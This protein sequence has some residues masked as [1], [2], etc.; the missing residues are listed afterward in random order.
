MEQVAGVEFSG[1][2]PGYLNR[3]SIPEEDFERHFLIAGSTKVKSTFPVV[4]SEKN[5]RRGNVVQAWAQ[6]DTIGR[7]IEQQLL[8]L[9]RQFDDDPLEDERPSKIEEL[10]DSDVNKIQVN[11]ELSFG[12]STEESL[13]FNQFSDRIGVGFNEY[14]VRENTN[15]SGELES[16][17][18]VFKAM[19]PGPPERRNGV[20]ITE[21]FLREVSSKEYAGEEPH[22]KDHETKN[23]FARIG[24]IEDLW[25]SDSVEALMLMVNTPNV[26]G[27][28]NHEE[29]I[30]RYTHE[31]P[32]IRDGSVGFGHQYEAVVN[33]DGEPELVDGQVQ[34]FSTVNF[35]GGYD[36]G[37]V[38]AAF[39]EAAQEAV[40]VDDSPEEDKGDENLAAFTISTTQK[41]I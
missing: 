24:G 8:S 6:R 27:S 40:P 33:D 37:G 36:E 19:E 25:Y 20:R 9:A 10:F 29:A 16:V 41:S 11:E 15:D 34:E 28:R 2:K 5:L 31:P 30:A 35:P 32:E 4:D 1:T 13:D 23:T 3:D 18:V 21:E 7:E 22:L 17:D 26:K 12:A 39:A 38:K 14:G